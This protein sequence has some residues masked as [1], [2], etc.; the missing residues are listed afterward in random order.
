MINI[1]ACPERIAC[2]PIATRWVGTSDV[3]ST[4]INGGLGVFRFIRVRLYHVLFY[5]T[6]RP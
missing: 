4:L 5:A 1:P 3:L 6:A 2:L